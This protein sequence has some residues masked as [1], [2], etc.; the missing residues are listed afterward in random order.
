MTPIG[1][2]LPIKAG[3]NGYF[4]QTYTTTDQIKTN[5]RNLLQTNRG[6]RRMNPHFY[7]QLGDILFEENTDAK[8]DIVKRQIEQMIAKWFPTVTIKSIK[9][10]QSPDEKNTNRDMYI[11]R[12][13]IEFIH[14]NQVDSLVLS[15]MNAE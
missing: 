7:S 4:D 2:T 15:Y 10:S 12:I 6:E 1:L 14:N 8:E 3:I 5:L 13:N 9:F 11:M